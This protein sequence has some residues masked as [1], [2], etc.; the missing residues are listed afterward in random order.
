VTETLKPFQALQAALQPDDRIVISGASGWMGRSLLHELY[1]AYPSMFPDRIL[2]LGKHSRVITVFDGPTVQVFETNLDLVRGWQPT[3]A[4]HLAYLTSDRLA[5][6]D[7]RH[8]VE[9]NREISQFGSELQGISSLRAFMFASS[10]AALQVGGKSAIAQHPYASQKALDEATYTRSESAQVTPTL[11]A[12]LWSVSGPHCTRPQEF[13]FSDMI[14]QHLQ[15][16]SIKVGSPGLVF[17]KYVDAGEF[18]SVCLTRNLQGKSGIID[19]AGDLVEIR[20]LARAISRELGG[21]VENYIVDNNVEQNVYY[22][23]SD[24][25]NVAALKLGVGF[26]DL[27]G[28]ILRTCEGLASFPG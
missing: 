24:S 5:H 26:T 19:S 27:R 25:M 22:S 18:L 15:T 9:M 28:Q 6:L 8:F 2:A 3:V 14:S 10:G 7:P 16:G 4:V 21:P 13:A 12:R 1:L 17:R 11:M 23:T 20:D